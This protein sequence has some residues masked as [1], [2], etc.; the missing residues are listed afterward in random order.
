MSSETMPIIRGKSSNMQF[1]TDVES[2]KE[3]TDQVQL[4]RSQ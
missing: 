1:V 4:S 2:E 3:E